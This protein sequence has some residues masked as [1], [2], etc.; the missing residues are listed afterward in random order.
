MQ[1]FS[2]LILFFVWHF[3]INAQTGNIALIT[4][5]QIGIP[6]NA[7]NL[8]RVVNDIN[9]RE[10]ISQVIILGNI[11]AN[12][13]FDEFLWAQEIL[14]G[15]NSPY[16]VVGGEKDYLLSEEKGSEISLLWGEDKNIIHGQN[17]SLICL[18]TIIHH[19]HIRSST[20]FQILT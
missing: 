2:I 15:L 7:E 6:E 4:E 20:V 10:N 14:D 8:I 1:K 17:F 3:I 11:T 13:K 9:L 12:G 5:P 18:N 19:M 16:F